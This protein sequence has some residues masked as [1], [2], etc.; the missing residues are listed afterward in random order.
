MPSAPYQPVNVA[1]RIGIRGVDSRRRR[2]T[3]QIFSQFS[4]DCCQ[5]LFASVAMPRTPLGF[6][7]P[8]HP[9]LEK[10][11]SHTHP[12]HCFHMHLPLAT[13]LLCKPIRSQRTWAFCRHARLRFLLRSLAAAPS[14]GWFRVVTCSRAELTAEAACDRAVGPTDPSRPGAVHCNGGQTTGLRG[15]ES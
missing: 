15:T 14:V 1:Y 5:N 2:P 7:A 10:V 3:H 4:I 6:T 12:S 8:P 13:P 11:G 9:Q